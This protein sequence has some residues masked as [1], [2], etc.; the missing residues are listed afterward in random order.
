M[1]ENFTKTDE[2]WGRGFKLE[3]YNGVF[4]LTSCQKGKDDGI[5]PEWVF[6]QDKDRKPRMKDN[7]QYMVIP[8][9]VVIGKSAEDAIAALQEMINILKGS[10]GTQSQ[11]GQAAGQQR[12]EPPP[13]DDS[14]IPF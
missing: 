7:G 11:R 9:K 2:K 13:F 14:K 10:P 8:V 12:N 4:S 3:E 5:Y 6:P 1:Q